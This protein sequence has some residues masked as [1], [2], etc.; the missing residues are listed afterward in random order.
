MEITQASSPA[1]LTER[2]RIGQ[3]FFPDLVEF[4]PRPVSLRQICSLYRGWLRRIS[5]ELLMPE[6]ASLLPSSPPSASMHAR[7][8]E[9]L[10]QAKRDAS[11][12]REW[13]MAAI[14]FKSMIPAISRS[15]L[16]DGALPEISSSS[17]EI[18]AAQSSA[19]S[20]KVLFVVIFRALL[21]CLVTAD[22]KTISAVVHGGGNKPVTGQLLR[23]DR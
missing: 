21:Q 19:T 3:R 14:R 18:W 9:S 23:I 22:Q 11:P 10:A 20:P 17:S 1:R 12:P 4:F 5:A 16:L 7:T 13:P 15:N 6:A 8:R 2:L